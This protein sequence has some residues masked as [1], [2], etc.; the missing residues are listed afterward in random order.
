M[1]IASAGRR[2]HELTLLVL[3]AATPEID[4]LDR[5]LHWVFQQ[6]VLKVG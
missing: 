4:N 6:D 5:A 3:E 1:S 2:V